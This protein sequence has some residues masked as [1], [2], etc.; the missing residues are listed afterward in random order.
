MLYQSTCEPVGDACLAVRPF[1]GFP[2]DLAH[3]FP[4]ADLVDD[5]GF[6]QADDAF[7]QG[8]VIG[9]TGGAD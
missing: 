4:G 8:V 2:F 5:L 6:E 3:R 9:V 1:Q 7:G